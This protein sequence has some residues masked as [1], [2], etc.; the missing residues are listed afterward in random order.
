MKNFFFVLF[1]LAGWTTALGQTTVRG[2]VVDANSEPIPGANVLIV[3]KAE[4]AVADFDG[5]FVLQTSENPPFTVRVTSIGFAD[6]TVSIT[7]NNQEITVVLEES[8]TALDEIVISASRT[9]ER[10]FESPV[11]VERFGLKGNS[12][13]NR[14]FL[15]RWS[16]EPQ[17]SRHQHQQFD[18]PV[19]QHQRFCHLC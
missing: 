14:S 9:P 8:S 18:V 13:Y 12:K 19:C 1:V 10:I 17:R 16:S 11:S 7:Q 2:K 15:L 5:N 6:K 4:G 3:G